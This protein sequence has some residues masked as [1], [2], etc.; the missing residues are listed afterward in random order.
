MFR[1]L[2][3]N[4]F[5]SPSARVRVF[6]LSV[7]LLVVP[8]AVYFSLHVSGRTKYYQERNFRQLSNFS[9]RIGERMD[10]LGVAFGNV[11]DKYVK[12][13]KVSSTDI[14]EFQDYLNVLKTTSTN[15]I[16][17]RVTIN[18]ASPDTKKTNPNTKN[19][20]Q[21]TEAQLRVSMRLVHEWGGLWLYFDCADS[22]DTIHLTAKTNFDQLIKP[23][24]TQATGS[25]VS[26]AEMT[27]E[28]D[29]IVIARVD[30]GKVLFESANDDLTL[31]SLDATP[32]ADASDKSLDLKTRSKTTDSIDVTLAGDRYKLYVQPIDITLQTKEDWQTKKDDN[33]REDE[34]AKEI[35]GQETHWVICGLVEASRFRYQTWAISHTVLIVSAFFA[36]LLLLSWPFL[37]LIF[38]GPKDRLRVA[39]TYML[40]ISVVIAAALLTFFFL[41]GVTYTQLEDKFDNQL[42][43]LATNFQQNFQEELGNALTQLDKLDEER[44]KSGEKPAPKSPKADPAKDGLRKNLLKDI[45]KGGVCPEQ[46]APYP[47]FK[48]VAWIDDAGKQVAK[49]SSNNQTTRKLDVANRDYFNKLRNGYYHE[50]NGKNFWIEPVYSRNTGSYTVVIS[51]DTTPDNV[52]K[53]RMVTLDTS[54]MSLSKPAMVAGFGYRVIDANGDVV[55]PNMKE[56]FFAESDHDSRLLSAV[57]GHLSD[58]VSVP[59]LG[60]DSRVYVT[61]VARIPEWTLVVFRD[62]EPL[63]SSYTEIVALSSALFV[64][65]CLPLLL[66]VVI[67]VLASMICG[68][69]MRW[70]WPSADAAPIY[71]QS[72]AISLFLMLPGYLLSFRVASTGAIL[73]LSLISSAALLLLV[74]SLARNWRLKALVKFTSR[75]EQKRS[76]INHRSLYSLCMATLFLL[77]AIF[78]SMIFFRLAYNEEMDLFV[79][80]GQMTLV[81]NLNEREQRIR[82]AYPNSNTFND[83]EATKKFIAGRLKEKF[84]R[85]SAFFFDT[86][87]DVSSGTNAPAAETPATVLSELRKWLPFSHRSSILRHGLVTNGSA[88]GLWQWPNGDNT[89]LTLLTSPGAA[90]NAGLSVSSSTEHFVMSSF[91]LI[92]FAVVLV[93]VLWLIVSFILNKVF[94]IGTV[95]ITK[96]S[97]RKLQAF[98]KLFMVLGA[99]FTRREERFLPVTDWKVLDLKDRNGDSEWLNTFNLETFLGG[100]SSKPIAVQYFE[101]QIDQPQYNLQ[102]LSLLEQ[103][104]KHNAGV[105]IT[106]TA[107]P[108]DYLFDVNGQASSG[109]YRTSEAGARWAKVLSNFWVDYR[110]DIGNPRNFKREISRIRKGRSEAKRELYKELMTECAPRASLQEIG[111]R[112][113][114][115]FD[116]D[117]SSTDELVREVLVQA[118]TYYR[119]IWESCSAN[120]KVTLTHLA[121]DGFLSV[122]DP[123]IERL[124]RRGLIVRQREVRLMNESFR[125]FVLEHGRSDKEVVFTEGQ[126]RKT[127]SWQYTK[128]ALSV[129]VVGIMVFLFATQRDLYNSTLVTLTSIAAGV[130]AVFNFFSLFQRHAAAVSAPPPAQ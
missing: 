86:K 35:K 13:D 11:V 36:L 50:L 107:E 1:R 130:P 61:P 91:T 80:Y 78:P 96:A 104:S 112:I 41:F 70:I 17:T 98:S 89:K 59:H 44:K 123:D 7:M 4:R 38:I 110:E 24:I 22:A 34:K 118:R 46:D 14:R 57:S 60:R 8:L 65:Y 58:F 111:R 94:L 100:E 27:E 3:V 33:T 114:N 18:K 117:N 54:L 115:R 9:R 103:L 75:L 2:R 31:S 84:D 51:K 48:M 74:V 88:D 129:V 127:S 85:Y 26:K 90:G 15:F 81:N 64:I 28:F 87:I 116:F 6:L 71:V 72:I 5:H 82:D 105:V 79:K 101:Y 40:A 43:Y 119:L 126:A 92:A 37:K 29:H 76:R 66:L 83:E 30:N 121:E 47:Y 125:Q 12:E 62:K 52:V 25:G 73:V 120:E 99:P 55:F 108:T 109:N 68:K 93:G 53:A 124:V 42:Y 122:N 16:P 77:I 20:S 106:S 10:N 69:R 49:W 21:N 128:V 39:E 19:A 102:K 32:L 56:N 95:E 23:L 63:R 67:L 45:C 113:A 97:R